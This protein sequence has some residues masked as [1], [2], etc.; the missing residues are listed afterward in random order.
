M[1]LTWN[2]TGRSFPTTRPSSHWHACT[3]NWILLPH[4][5]GSLGSN[6]MHACEGKT[7][8]KTWNLR[9]RTFYEAIFC[10]F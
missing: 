9:P 3:Y 4:S 1:D 2:A 10:R 8:R 5:G 7:D 6:T